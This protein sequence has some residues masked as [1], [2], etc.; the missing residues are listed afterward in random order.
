MVDSGVEQLITTA[1]LSQK[2]SA[3][4][5]SGT[6]N[7]RSLYLSDLVSSIEFFKATISDPKVLDSTVFCF[8]EYQTTG[9]RFMKIKIPV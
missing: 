8:L 4:P 1:S 9:A 2:M 5:S 6:P 3:G 7:I